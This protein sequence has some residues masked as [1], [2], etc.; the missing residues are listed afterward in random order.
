M[1]QC[2]RG[3]SVA[4]QELNKQLHYERCSIQ[5]H[6]CLQAMPIKLIQMAYKCTNTQRVD[7]L[8]LNAIVSNGSIVL[9]WCS[10]FV[11]TFPIDSSKTILKDYGYCL[12]ISMAWTLYTSIVSLLLKWFLV[13]N[14]LTVPEISPRYHLVWLAA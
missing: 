3:R 2:H 9:V 13:L 8:T 12:R 10:R 14:N 4:M 7:Q 6:H 5:S 1:R 11:M